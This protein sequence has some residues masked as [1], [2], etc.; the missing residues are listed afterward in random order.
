[1]GIINF[2]IQGQPI[3]KKNSMRIMKRGNRRWIAPSEQ[4]CNYQ[5]QCGWLIPSNVKNLAL[6]KKYNVKCI[7]YMKTKGKV[8][9]LNLLGATMDILVKYNVLKD[10]DST[11]VESRD[12]SRVYYDKNNPRVEIEI[13]EMVI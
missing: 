13:C 10:D 9:L 11:I 6:D 5:D 4:F 7:Y 1:M 8:D 3:T 12:G 2:T